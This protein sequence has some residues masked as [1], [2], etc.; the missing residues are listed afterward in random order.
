MEGNDSAASQVRVEVRLL[1]GNWS[2]TALTDREGDFHIDGIP[3]ATYLVTVSNPGYSTLQETLQIDYGTG[4][5]LLRLRK[6]NQPLAS[7]PR[8]SVS[9]HELII[10]QKARN[11]FDKG[12]HLLASKNPAASIEEY[13]RAIQVFPDFYEAYYSIGVAEL[14]QDHGAE[15]EAAFSKS[16]ELSEGRYAP[17]MSSLSLIL[18]IRQQFPEAELV[19]RQALLL[20]DTDAT[21]HYALALVLYSTGR[22]PE[23][24]KSALETLHYKPRFGEAF[25]LLAQIHQRQNNPTAVVADL[26]AYLQIDSNSPRAAKAKAVRADAQNALLQQ[27]T[28]ATLAKTTP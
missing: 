24:E 17:P 28:G 4:P 3:A 5:L 21:S 2:A 6:S 19:A 15:A 9:V 1:A 11:F 18:C 10:P 12:N 8:S 25:L 14:N 13:K 26:D 20:D 22:N 7:N 27:I 23:A 16:I